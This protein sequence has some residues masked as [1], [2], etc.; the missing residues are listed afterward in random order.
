MTGPCVWSSIRR[1]RIRWE[2]CETASC[3]WKPSWG[4]RKSSTRLPAVDAPDV[5]PGGLL[6]D[7]LPFAVHFQDA[8]PGVARHERVAVGQ[9][10]RVVGPRDLALP[11]DLALRA[12]LEDLPLV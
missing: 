8:L 2:G 7:G 6:P 4:R 10:R 11:D 5:V 1:T 12:Q 3:S 9:A